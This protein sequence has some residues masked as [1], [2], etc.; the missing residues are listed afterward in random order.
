MSQQLTTD[1][2]KQAL[3]QVIDTDSGKDVVSAGLISG[4]VIRK[5]K[6]GFVITITPDARERMKQLREACEYAVMQLPGVESVTA[7]MTAHNSEPIAPK[8]QSGYDKPRERATWNLTPLDGVKHIIAVASGKGGVGKSTTTINLAHAL[9]DAGQKVGILDADIYGPSIPRMLGLSHEKGANQP[10]IIDN[11]MQPLVAHG[12]YCMSMGFITGDEAAILR[13]PMITKALNQMLRMTNW[14]GNGKPL[15]TLLVDMP[16]GTGDIHLSMVQQVPLSGAVIVT[17]PQGVATIDARK[18][19]AMFQ[20]VNVPVLGVVENMSGSIFGSGG[21]KTLAGNSKVPFL[22]AVTMDADICESADN[23][24]SYNG[25]AKAQ[26]QSI[27]K[28]LTQP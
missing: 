9:R 26:Y 3:A 15:D 23:G 18:C 21:G 24:S 16:P 2:V 13:A 22:G 27:A 12:I 11:K 8:P 4:V 17:T 1:T 19:L 5:G 7:V 28:Q 25:I 20:K 14:A 10:E 6:V